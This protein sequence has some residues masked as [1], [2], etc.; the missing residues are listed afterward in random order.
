[1]SDIFQSPKRLIA[2]ADENIRN[3]KRKTADLFENEPCEIF[4]EPHAEDVGLLIVK[5]RLK[6]PLPDYFSEMVADI[7]DHLRSALDQAIYSIA[8]L[9]GPVNPGDVYFPFGRNE[10]KFLN[11][12]E[13]RC[14]GRLKALHPLLIRLQPYKGGNETLWAL[15]AAR[16]KQHAFLLPAVAQGFIHKVEWESGGGRVSIPATPQW[17][18]AKNEIELFTIGAQSRMKGNFSTGFHVIFGEVEGIAG[19]DVGYVLEMFLKLVTMI[20]AEIES[21]ATRLGILE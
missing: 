7:L 16:G 13:G 20:I 11:T 17:D 5:A 9:D 18:S 3:L 6:K 21:E 15:N 4:T 19:E 12:M 8:I 10:T 14:P 1:M 2:W